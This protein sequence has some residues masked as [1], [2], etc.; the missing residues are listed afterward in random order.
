M[1]VSIGGGLLAPLIL[2]LVIFPMFPAR[3]P[4]AYQTIGF[5]SGLA[6]IPPLLITFLG[7]R[8]RVEFQ[9]AKPLPLRTAVSYVIRNRAFHYTVGL[10][11]LSWTPVV[12]VEAVFAYYLIYWAGMTEDETSIVQGI[13]LAMALFLLPLVRYLSDRFEKKHAYIIAAGTWVVVMIALFFVPEGITTPVYIIAA[14]AGFGVSAAHVIPTAMSPDVLEVD[15]LMSGQRQ[16]GA[17]A[18]IEV[19]INKLARMIALA[20]VPITLK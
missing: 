19:F 15:E 13:I 11:L 4:R 9:R 17:Y 20:I 8:E 1:A 5:A 18:G 3:S 10:H 12:I 2:G 6:F 14:L 7:T 16:E